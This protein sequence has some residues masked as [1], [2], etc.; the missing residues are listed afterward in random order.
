MGEIQTQDAASIPQASSCTGKVVIVGAGAV[1]STFAY[2]MQLRG[3]ARQ[4]VL[5]DRNRELA[6]AEASDLSHGALFAP[7]VEITAGD[8]P[9]C[10]D[11]DLVAICA[12]SAQKPG[13]SRMELVSTNVG[14]CKT[15]VRQVVEHTSKATILIVTNPVDVLT[16]AAIKYSGLPTNQVIGSGTV[17]DSARLRYML[18]RHCRV[19]ARNIHGYV[20]GEHGDSEM[21]AWSAVTIGGMAIGKYCPAC[22]RHC[23][24]LEQEQLAAQVRDS[25]YHIIEAKGATNYAVGQAMTHIATAIL[26][27]ENSVLTVSTLLNGEY[28]LHD[29]CLSVP[30]IINR[31]GVERILN[32]QL[33]EP[34]LQALQ[35]SAEAIKNVQR[36]V[37]L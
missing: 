31:S 6:E 14:I 2:A 32:L 8:Y 18:S 7:P 19:D 37:G 20:L 26:R 5:I 29:V 24:P 3:A 9:D 12:G 4:I 17:L 13:Q 25:A 33:T 11:A 23:P 36:E 22:P 10:A 21:V 34:E 28:G 16:Y 27:N 35:A 1:G 15:I 30:V